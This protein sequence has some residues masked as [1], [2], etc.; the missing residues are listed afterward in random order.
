MDETLRVKPKL[1][2]RPKDVGDARNM[3]CLLRK[4][5]VNE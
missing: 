5:S 3:G 1:Q 4:T 2:E